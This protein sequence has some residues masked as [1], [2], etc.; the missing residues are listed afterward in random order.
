[1]SPSSSYIATPAASWVDDFLSWLN[2]AL[3]KCCREHPLESPLGPGGQC[4]PPDQP[5]CSTNTTDC[6]DCQT[7]LNELPGGRPELEQ[8][9]QFLPWFLK[10][11]PSEACAKG[12]AGAYNTAIEP[13]TADRTGRHIGV[14]AALV[15]INIK[16]LCC[17]RG[18]SSCSPVLIGLKL[19]CTNMKSNRTAAG[20][21]FL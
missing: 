1:M 4:P 7:C 5:P 12:G 18:S 21:P 6:A 13:S 16:L 11:L 9:Q 3:P 17:I 19:W 14:E 20:F 15:T 8:V 10:A 2:P